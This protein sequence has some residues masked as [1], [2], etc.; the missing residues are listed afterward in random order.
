ALAKLG[1][2]RD[3]A[4]GAAT[5]AFRDDPARL[6]AVMLASSACDVTDALA[7]GS[8]ARDPEL[9][10]AGLGGVLSGGAAAVAG[11]WA[12]SRLRG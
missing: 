8:A 11:F 9:R 7:L 2:G 3:I 1:G 12:A 5:L 4:L 6:R 10:L